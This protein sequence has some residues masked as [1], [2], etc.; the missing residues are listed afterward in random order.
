MYRWVYLCFVS[1][2][3][4]F[5]AFK[6]LIKFPSHPSEYAS[7]QLYIF[8]RLGIFILGCVSTNSLIVESSVNPCVPP[9]SVKTSM[10]VEEYRQYPDANSPDPGWSTA[11]ESEL[12]SLKSGAD[13]PLNPASASNTPNFILILCYVCVV[14]VSQASKK[15]A[16]LH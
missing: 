12:G 1:P 11:R 10:V 15:S 16:F 2:L 7:L 14:E 8:P 3:P 13:P 9:P 5:S 6:Y 4:V